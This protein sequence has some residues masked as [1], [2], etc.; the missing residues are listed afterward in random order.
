M[1]SRVI[2]ADIS[3]AAFRA[4]LLAVL[5]WPGMGRAQGLLVA[6][7]SGQ[8]VRLPRPVSIRP[9]PP[10]PAPAGTYKIQSID[11]EVRLR[12]EVAAV[13]VAQT[14]VN[15]GSASM[16]VA[17]LF[18]LPYDGAVDRMTLV[19]DGKELPARLLGAKEA[20]KIYEEIARKNRDPALLEWIGT[21]MFKT[22]VF[23]VPAGAACQVQIRYT[24]L[25]RT[26]GGLTDFLLP[27]K[28][29]KYTS[30]AV[31]KVHVRVAVEARED[32][33]NV[34]SP[35]H[36][37]DIQ[38]GD[39]RHATVTFTSRNKVPDRDFRLLF[40][41]GEGAIGARVVSYRPEADG[42]GFF[43]LLARPGMQPADQTA[44]NKTVLFV[45]DRSG[46]MQGKKIEQVRG[47]LR[48]VL[49]NLKEGDRF[50]IIA[51]DAEV[52]SFRP[53]IERFNNDSRR[54]ALGFVESLSAG[55]S[56]NIDA[57]LD[58]ALSQLQ[59]SRPP[60]YIIFLTDGLPTAGETV[61]AR[62]VD[63]TRQLNQRG[64]RL[65]AFGVGYDVNSRLLDKLAR[66]NHGQTEYVRPDEDIEA[67]VARFYRQISDPV[68]TDV[69]LSI[70]AK[71]ARPEDGPTVNRLIPGAVN[72]LFAGQQLV[73]VGRYRQSGTAEVR[74][75][76][77]LGGAGEQYVFPVEL[78][79]KSGDRSN[80]FVEKIWAMRRV[81]EI[82]DQLDLHGQ[83]E[84]LVAEL[85]R[86]AT[87]HGILTPYTSFLADER[88]D[89]SRSAGLR[90]ETSERLRELERVTGRSAFAQR[91][92]KQYYQRADRL[93]ATPATVPG[94]ALV[95]VAADS[96]AK[97]DF[98]TVRTV[99]GKTFFRRHG[100]W[101]DSR[102]TGRQIGAARRIDRFS[103]AF[104]EL[105]T[106][107][108]EE[109]GAY[110]AFDEPV[111]VELGG[112]VYEW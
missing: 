17:F 36:A 18:P 27:L 77:S 88:T 51:Y 102:V 90:R 63:H 65:M 56:T 84:E 100:R 53:E 1:K 75:S 7:D 32:I 26:Q 24:Q 22:S 98:T 48:F 41:A 3:V 29:A 81:G 35:T 78:A 99:A 79:S 112:T 87:E 66:A 45:V 10:R 109:I 16:E 96:G 70:A 58:E 97:V 108:G 73:V 5:F 111:V 71:G 110:L 105:A 62:I 25:C 6:T 30:L 92:A 23:P 31:E 49:N 37:V 55:G 107:Y 94:D 21:G 42:D 38:Q 15:T 60:N 50:N 83:N 40:D 44:V 72:D 14:F 39:A 106:R 74:I 95:A 28:T 43:L 91:K 68:L 20:R 54:A 101:I 33:K 82:L 59:E 9:H 61:S 69:T 103:D 13:E 19:V 89:V 76:G 57:A 64:A 2:A 80:R 11:V 12:D 52:E 8:S 67:S 34:Y 104:F 93:A 46:S 47:A 85:V 4:G 86:L